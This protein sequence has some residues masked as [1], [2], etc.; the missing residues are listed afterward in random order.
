MSS[1][2]APNGLYTLPAVNSATDED[3]WGDE[4]NTNLNTLDAG[5]TTRTLDLDC[6]DYKVSRPEIKDY[7]ETLAT[8]SSS[9]GTLTL[10]YST[11]P[12]FKTTLTEN[13]TTITITN[14]PPTGK[15]GVLTLKIKQASGASYTVTHPSLVKWIGSAPTMTATNNAVDFY[16]YVTDDAFTTAGGFTGGQG[17]SGWV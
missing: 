4:L 15:R 8:V 5:Y 17:F 7:C 14:A 11:G 16:A 3:L 2:S 10:D 6:A 12:H 9:S 1:T 13:I